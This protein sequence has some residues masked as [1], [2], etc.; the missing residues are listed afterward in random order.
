VIILPAFSAIEQLLFVWAFFRQADEEASLFITDAV[1]FETVD[2][3]KGKR[4]F[5]LHLLY[6]FM[7]LGGCLPVDALITRANSWNRGLNV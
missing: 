3:F 6:I 5:L 1:T 4:D 7:K 2:L